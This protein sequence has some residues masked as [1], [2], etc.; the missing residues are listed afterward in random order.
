MGAWVSAVSEN[1]FES[2]ARVGDY[3]IERELVREESGVVYQAT[4]MVLPRKAHVKVMAGEYSR[5]L[6]VQLLREAC[7]LEALQHAGIPRVYECGVLADRKPWVATQ[8]IDGLSLQA[9]LGDGPMAI[10]ELVTVL[11]DVAD[12]LA[13]A[14]SR[15]VVHT[16]LSA[17]TIVRTPDRQLSVYL[18]GWS[19]AR[20]VES[21]QSLDIRDDVYALG[22]VAFRALTGCLHTPSVSATEW[23]PAAPPELTALIDVMLDTN[24]RVRPTSDEVRERARW[25][26]TTVESLIGKPRWTPPNG[27]DPDT[28][29]NVPVPAT[30]S[31]FSIRIARSPTK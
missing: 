15:G 30:S 1:Y 10:A 14:H 8:R 4:H 19:A 25:L 24:Q 2:G 20:T 27:I 3:T 11:R 6:A 9:S 29:D 7:L 22:V 26:A 31:A 16:K 28:H 18:R 13:H 21:T 17:E 12:I 23:C 5:P